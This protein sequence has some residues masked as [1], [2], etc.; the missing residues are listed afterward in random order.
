MNL[1]LRA[2]P[3]SDLALLRPLLAPGY[4]EPSQAAASVGARITHIVFPETATI[5]LSLPSPYADGIAIGVI[6]HEGAIGWS[7]LLG[8]GFAP[9]N[10]V[11]GLVG[12]AVRTIEIAPFE[13]ACAASASLKALMLCFAQAM[14]AQ[15]AST[16]VCAIQDSIA[17]RLA[18]WLLMLH[19][20]LDGDEL[21]VTH[22]TL[23]S[24][25]GIRRASVTDCLHVLEGDHV[26]RCTRGRILIRD[27][28]A[29]E[30]AAGAAYGSAEAE[31]RRLIAP[32]GRQGPV[33]AVSP[34]DH[35]RRLSERTATSA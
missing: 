14:T 23:A 13:R 22:D 8:Q 28:D 16:A 18:R 19:D 24:E 29:L 34:V 25:L 6:G 5:T 9:F 12:G 17:R 15:L 32:F 3:P 31:Y 35:V 27:R 11:A 26:V 1:L 10:A 20:R 30:M 33:A 4:L 21:A 7:A 2:M